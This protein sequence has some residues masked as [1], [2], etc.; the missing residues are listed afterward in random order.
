MS[1]FSKIIHKFWKPPIF[2]FFVTNNVISDN[3]E[4]QLKREFT[5]E[6]TVR[7]TSMNPRLFSESILLIL[8]RSIWPRD[9]SNTNFHILISRAFK[10]ANQIFTPTDTTADIRQNMILSHLFHLQYKKLFSL[11]EILKF[12]S[13]KFVPIRT[14]F[15]P[16]KD[17][18]KLLQKTATRAWIHCV[19]F[20]ANIELQWPTKTWI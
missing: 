20:S 3:F 5:F 6:Y 8:S 4:T 14:S 11:W 2:L 19:Q 10:W 15:E 12:F 7:I 17:I 1:R 16:S 9:K 18:S 13:T